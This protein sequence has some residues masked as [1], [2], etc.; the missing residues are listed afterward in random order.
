MS[1][2]LYYVVVEETGVTRLLAVSPKPLHYS[3][4][5]VGNGYTN[6]RYTLCNGYGYNYK[7]FQCNGYMTLGFDMV[8]GTSVRVCN[9]YSYN[10]T[11][12]T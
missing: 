7:P 2:A 1:S 3:H 8:Y 4:V 11:I 12:S 5:T 9:R 6:K 10:V